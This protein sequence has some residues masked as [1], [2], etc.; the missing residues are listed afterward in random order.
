MIDGKKIKKIIVFSIFC[1]V[2]VAFLFGFLFVAIDVKGNRFADFDAQCIDFALSIRSGWLTVIF[3]IITNLVNPIVIGIVGFCIL[4]FARNRRVFS[5]QL[6]LNI[7]IVALLNQVFKYFF[8]RNRPDESLHLVSEVGYSFPSGHT[9]F[10]VA[11]Y[12]FLIYM[13][14]HSNRKKTFKITLSTLGVILILLISFSRIYLGVHY[15]SD[16]IGGLCVS[17]GYLMIYLFV[18]S[19]TNKVPE[20]KGSDYK[21]HTFL[22][23]FK[24]AGKGVITAIQEENNLLIQFSASM[25]V[26]VFGV[27]LRISLVEWCICLIM[28]FLVMSLELVNTS[29]ENLCDRVTMK[30][31]ESIKKIKDISAGAVLIMSIC[32][33]IV[34]AI[35]FIP[36]VPFLF[37]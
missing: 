37:K 1:L 6:F 5:F 4:L 12:G 8:V 14:W 9:M 29:F 11:F 25:L 26:V 35:I 3:T 23:G 32:S 18:I 22:G 33:L 31:D 2:A 28:C 17:I 24:Y 36:K 15:A 21:R 30:R 16:V 27:A 13:L 20:I 34:A 10:A 19:R 7:G